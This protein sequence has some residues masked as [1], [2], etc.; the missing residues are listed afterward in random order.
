MT[1][2]AVGAAL[3]GFR[4]EALIG[5]GSMGS[6][7]SAQD[8]ALDRRVAVKV[9]APAL[10]R[11]ER[12]RERFLRES[13][14]VASL[15]H[16]NIVPI[17]AAGEEDG[18]LYLAMRYV[19]G[20]DLASLL[21]SL[22]RVDAERAVELV[23]QIANALD[24]A[25]ARGLIHRDVKPANIL[26]A[27]HHGRADHAYLC[28]FGL[29]KHASTVSS[30]TGD[31]GIVGTVEYLAPE[32]IEGG[33]V[34]GR[35]DVY[36]LGCVL[37]ELLTGTAPFSRGN[38][39]GA[40]LAHVSDPPPKVSERRPELSDAWDDVIA[41]ALAKDRDARYSTCGALVDAARAALRGE[42]GDARPAHVQSGA[43][44]TFL[45]A[46]VR[47]Y[48]SYTR[49]HGDEAGAEL[50][51][52]F[53]RVVSQVAPHHGG[54]LQELRGDEALVV[55][56]SA[57]AA[58]RFALALQAEVEEHGLARPIGVGL[59][60]GEAV[61]VADGFRGGA[62]NRA[63]RLCALAGPR[64]VL[65]TDA[66]R[67]LAGSTDGVAYGFRRVE[68]LKGFERP[69]GVIEVHPS[70]RAPGREL[71]R[72]VGR[73]LFGARPRRR[74]AAL[75][76][77]LVLAGAGIGFLATRHGASS[78]SVL[79]T[80]SLGILDPA[81]GR[82]AG[83]LNPG[84]TEVDALIK[85]GNGFWALSG[86]NGFFLQQIDA[87]QRTVT[88]Q[89]PLAHAPYAMT[90]R[91]AFGAIWLTWNEG[92]TPQ[93]IRFDVHFGRISARIRLPLA[94]DPSGHQAEGVAA[95]PDAIWV[96][97]GSP[98]RLAKIDP[99]T[100][101]ITRTVILPRGDLWND[102]LLTAGDGQLWAI[103][104]SGRRVARL[105]PETG[106]VLAQGKIHD[107][108]VEDAA[109]AG[110]S[111]WLPVENDGGVWQLDKSA[112]IVGKTD[113]GQVPWALAVDGSSVYVSNQNSGTVTRINALTRETRQFSVGHRPLALGVA[114]GRL[115]VFVGQSAEEARARITGSRVVEAVTP[116]DPFFLTDPATLRG[117]EQHALQYA[118]GVR[119]MD[120]RVAT[121]G[122]T[123]LYPSGA[124]SEP[125]VSNNGRTYTFAVRPGFRYSPPSGAD[126]TAA[127]WK[128][129]IERAV[130]PVYGTRETS[131]CHAL[132]PD[133]A[134]EDAYDA[135]RATHLRGIA[136]SGTHISFTLTAPSS[137]FPAR[138]A[139]ACFTSVPPGTPA[140][141][142]GVAQPIASAG[143]YY[144]DS[145]IA[146]EQLI[147]RPNP[148]YS[149][150]RQRRLDAIVFRNGFD[151]SKAA[152]L[153]AAG[154]TA[155]Y[156]FPSGGSD[157]APSM[158]AGGL[159]ARTL[160]TGPATERRFFEPAT[161]GI[162][163]LILNTT[164]GP[165]RDVRLR[166]AIALAVN[167]SAIARID[168]ALPAASMIPPGIP[169]YE[170]QPKPA[171]DRLRR[172]RAL[173]GNRRVQLSLYT[174]EGRDNSSQ[175]RARIVR[176]SLAA[177]GID[178]SVHV[179]GDPWSFAR[180]HN[181]RVDMMLDGWVPDF[182]DPADIINELLDPARLADGLYPPFFKETPWLVRMR[183]A[184]KVT[185]RGRPAAYARLDHELGHGPTPAVPLVFV[186][187]T[188]QLFSA[189]VACHTF[190]PQYNGLVDFAS[191]CLK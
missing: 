91:T 173:V 51:Q 129:S 70:Q 140:L 122:R 15:E 115:W 107:G 155:D 31:R 170:T 101:R 172:A 98:K 73:T 8:M 100:N 124:V 76:A 71:G 132:M 125:T 156:T 104:R 50:A 21:T 162:R 18:L 14:L 52:V 9:L 83:S 55:F 148:N 120:V 112:T 118:V 150:P 189:R 60:A 16:P 11:D 35:V 116:G 105:D 174:Y 25:H 2:L 68:R 94:A 134:G 78:G 126:V 96:A 86:S 176:A 168:G 181:D 63:A 54:T 97:Y 190:L 72:S 171:L 65:A 36:A 26:L 74:I 81:T 141:S 99:R 93:L 23:A 84:S 182:L 45:F 3:A 41:T 80:G 180:R 28:D 43:V 147:L 56:D 185:G 92:E 57:R 102:T 108:F 123:E 191:L 114:A 61:A 7:Y 5:R 33:P 143:P 42:R 19:D 144:I 188:P 117:I 29:A 88:Q 44:R 177:I 47:G 137:T 130:S 82:L 157:P 110:G 151:P 95:T 158:T 79:P 103:D 154:A 159:Y 24:A 186:A 142:D 139:N 30:L 59:D 160:G 187:G 152:S 38:E 149:G 90:P 178:V 119:L 69:V 77:L 1:D 145:H 12:F 22:G 40:L 167:R 184:E 127:N 37:Y 34:D 128:F 58:L 183:A 85:D 133:I 13:R 164:H 32:Q 169:G 111:L 163:S 153:V 175:E 138:L 179:I 165:L 87:A 113:T 10:A 106:D 89:V 161:S 109:V 135:H 27:H 121:D 136:V 48:T 146:G 46:D 67:E 6:V 66:V 166:Q 62:L 39:L 53:A 131:Y 17:Y 49:E 75:A 20:R 4:I 64:E